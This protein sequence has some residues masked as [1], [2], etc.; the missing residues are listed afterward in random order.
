MIHK[1]LCE[2]YNNNLKA[3]LGFEYFTI[4]A[5]RANMNILQLLQ[6]EPT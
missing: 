1:K 5:N 2:K 3:L 6:I 4:I